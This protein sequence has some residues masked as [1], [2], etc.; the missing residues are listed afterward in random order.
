MQKITDNI[1]F[2][3]VLLSL[4]AIKLA[5]KW[6]ANLDYMDTIRYTNEWYY[7]FYNEHAIY[8]KTL[9]QISEYEDLAISKTLK[10]TE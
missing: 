4:I 10:W 5:V 2:H 9:N 7:H 8:N 3:E 6:N 1:T